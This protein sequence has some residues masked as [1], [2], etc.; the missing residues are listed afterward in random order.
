MFNSPLE[1][2]VKTE[3]CHCRACLTRPWKWPSLREP[4]SGL[5]VGWEDRWRRGWRTVQLVLSGRR[6]RTRYCSVV[7]H[8][9]G[10]VVIGDTLRVLS[11]VAR[12]MS[13]HWWHATCLATGDTLHLVTSDTLCPVTG[14]T[15]YCHCW[16]IMCHVTGDTSCVMSLVTHYVSCH[17]WHAMC[18]VTGDTLRVLSWW[19]AT[20]PVTGD[21][22]RVLSWWHATCPVTGDT[23]CVMSL[24]TCYISCH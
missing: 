3:G 13:C 6:L 16:H 8:I 2:V 18:P 1:V 9:V 19:H 5:W 23:L 14:D 7:G 15:I 4:T 12:Y 21:T 10:D 17:W 22:L 24:V 20:C 11:L